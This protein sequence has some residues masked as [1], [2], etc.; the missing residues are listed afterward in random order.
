MAGIEEEDK[1]VRDDGDGQVDDDEG[2]D[3]EVG[4]VGVEMGEDCDD[5]DR[6]DGMRGEERQRDKAQEIGDDEGRDTEEVH[7]EVQE[8]GGD[9]SMMISRN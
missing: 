2:G 9:G 3:D 1:W 6:V 5:G 4:I 7:S 8:E